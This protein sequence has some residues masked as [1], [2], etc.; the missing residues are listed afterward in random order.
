[1]NRVLVGSALR[2]NLPRIVA[3][4]IGLGLWGYLL[5]IVY[6]TFGADFRELVESG[7]FGDVVELLS[8]FTGGNVFS[9][10]GSIALGFLHPVPISL[11]TVLA[12]GYPIG[13]LAGER[14]RGTIEV[15]LARPIG[16]RSLLG[17]VLVVLVVVVSVAVAATLVGAALAA[18]VEGVGD[19]LEPSALAACWLNGVFLYTAIGCVAILASASSDRVV[20]ALGASLGFVIASYAVEVIGTIWPDAAGLRPWSVFHYLPASDV[21]VGRLDP[22]DLAVLGGVAA[23]SFGLALV[24]YPRRDLA[25]PT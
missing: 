13:A 3:V 6:A 11:V 18:A 24:I 12:V 4:S 5:T 20:P 9:L 7:L 22:L 25:A 2:T 19:E 14:Q 23:G 15:L 8:A 17:A 10:A 21:L 16:R 1:M